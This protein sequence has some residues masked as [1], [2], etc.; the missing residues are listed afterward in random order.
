M[1]EAGY[2]GFGI[3][4]KLITA[5]R[6][7]APQH[8]IIA[9]GHRWSGPYELLFLEPYADRNI[10][11]NFH[12]YEPFAFTHQGATWAGANVAFYKEVP[13]PSSPEGVSKML[14]TVQ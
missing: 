10:I 2:R 12:F 11:Y 14:D 5:I 9:S 3:Q 6:A 13:Y 8:T 4:G 7:G 1:V